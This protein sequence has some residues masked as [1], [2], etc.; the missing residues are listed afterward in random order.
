M[1]LI[2]AATVRPILYAWKFA[3]QLRT[4]QSRMHSESKIRIP[5]GTLQHSRAGVGQK[6]KFQRRRIPG[7]AACRQRRL[8]ERPAR[9]KPP[10]ELP[11]SGELPGFLSAEIPESS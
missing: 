1:R 3:V 7:I 2:R 8:R 6:E 11:S 4:G 10:R 9:L 5:A